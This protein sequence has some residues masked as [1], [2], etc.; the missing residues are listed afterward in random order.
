MRILGIDLGTRITGWGIIS[1][2]VDK[3]IVVSCGSIVLK[4]SDA[5]AV[6]LAR[7]TGELTS[8]LGEWQPYEA[9]VEAPFTGVN[10]RSALLLAH[11]R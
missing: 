5:L 3:P 7:L 8:I 10:A 1:G 9:A 6:R 11:A 2:S 4:G